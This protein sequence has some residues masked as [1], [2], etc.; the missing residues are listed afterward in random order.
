MTTPGAS[1][2]DLNVDFEDTNLKVPDLQDFCKARALPIKQGSRRFT[3]LELVDSLT[4]WQ[5]EEHAKLSAPVVDLNIDLETF[6]DRFG[7][8]NQPQLLAEV[9]ARGITVPRN[10]LQNRNYCAN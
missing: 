8:M 5:R 10:N 9:T 7:T 4:A 1:A 3:K 6:Q 2:P